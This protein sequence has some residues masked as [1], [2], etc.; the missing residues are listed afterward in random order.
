MTNLNQLRSKALSSGFLHVFGANLFSYF[1]AFSGSIIYVR[2]LG[3]HEYGIYAFT[4]NIISFFLLVNGFG[5][6]SGV[7]QFVSKAPDKLTQYAYLKASMILGILFNILLSIIIF[8]YAI[9]IN[10]PI[11][12]ARTILIAMAFFPIGRLFIDVFQAY[13]RAT[14][15]NKIL[16]RFAISS[17]L[18]LLISSIIGIYYFQ[19]IGFILFTYIAYFIIIILTLV[20]FNFPNILKIKVTNLNYSEFI[21]YSM[22]VTTGNAFSQLL[23]VL[24]VLL[25][26]YV[27]KDVILVAEYKV[28]TIIP[29]TLSF[30]P[31]II[32]NF[33]YPN[34]ARNIQNPCYIINLKNRLRKCMLVLSISISLSLIILAKPIIWIIYGKAYLNSV[35]PFQILSFG[36]WVAASFRTVNGSILAS[37]GHAKFSM[38]FNVFMLIL[39]LI[40]SYELI[41][42]YGIVGA[43]VGVV[44]IFSISSIVSTLVLNKLL[45]RTSTKN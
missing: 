16:A 42:V 7:L 39:N 9:F 40:I 38:W 34:F 27:V 31:N 26:G 8:C 21:R 35:I 22:Y 6:A 43:A 10:L 28:A 19:L 13:L 14:S 11:P 1:V 23:F 44:I 3:Q 5:A 12:G 29:F 4:Y 32:C 20:W 37:L 41:K 24:D 15:Q 33:F 45:N 36:F 30:I 17:N 2:L 25:L 18:T